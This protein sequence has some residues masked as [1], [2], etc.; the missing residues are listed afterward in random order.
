MHYV[1]K[2][3]RNTQEAWALSSHLPTQSRW[4]TVICLN[5]R[6]LEDKFVADM[7]PRV[8]KKE[9]NKSSSLQS[10]GLLTLV[11]RFLLMPSHLLSTHVCLSFSDLTVT[12]FYL[13]FL[14]LGV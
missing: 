7:R 2:T 14:L 13:F 1:W 4:D 11:L 6:K 5:F 8:E 10:M 3:A 12:L 9:R